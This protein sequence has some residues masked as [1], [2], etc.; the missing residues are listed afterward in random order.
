[1]WGLGVYW[2]SPHIAHTMVSFGFD[3]GRYVCISIETR[4]RKGQTYSAL[5]GFFRQYELTYVVGDER[6]LVGLRARHRGEQVY[7][8]RLK[9]DPRLIREVFLDYL[10][11]VNS[12]VCRPEWYNALTNNCTTNI[13][14]HT[15]PYAPKSRW[16]WRLILNGRLDEMIYETGVINRDLPFDE[17]RARSNITERVKTADDSPDF[18]RRIRDGLPGHAD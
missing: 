12:L 1:M 6:D 10:A 16:D 5:R 11:T 15:R 17:L 8:Y 14:G 2:G 9:A 4:K 7:L 13:R 18:S 3:D